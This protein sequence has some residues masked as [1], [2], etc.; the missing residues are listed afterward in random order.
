MNVMLRWLSSHHRGACWVAALLTLA[1]SAALV[2][3]GLR[4]DYTLESFVA[5]GDESYAEF[6]RFTQE[7]TSNEIALIAVRSED[8][9]SESSLAIL[10]ELVASVKTLRAVEHVG[11]ITEIPVVVRGLMGSRLRTHPLIE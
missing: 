1:G 9:M 4:R 11:A 7:F 8:A 10:R 3:P 2:R 6:H 5:S